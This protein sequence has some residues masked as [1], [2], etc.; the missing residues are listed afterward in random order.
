M[1]T[2]FYISNVKPP[3]TGLSKPKTN[4]KNC[5][6]EIKSIRTKWEKNISPKSLQL[7]LLNNQ[8]KKKINCTSWEGARI[9]NTNNL[10]FNRNLLLIPTKITLKVKY[11]IDVLVVLILKSFELKIT[12]QLYSRFRIRNFKKL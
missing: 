11:L 12:F 5:P 2:R 10:M 9:K 1:K 6:R 7:R 3:W 8:V 4:I